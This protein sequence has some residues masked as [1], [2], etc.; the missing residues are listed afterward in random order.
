MK[1]MGKEF[2]R[3]KLRAFLTSALTVIG[4]LHAAAV[5]PRK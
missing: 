2:E 4:K 3:K 5:L 1:R